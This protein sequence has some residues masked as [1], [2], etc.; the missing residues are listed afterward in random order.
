M[1]KVAADANALAKG[2]KSGAIGPSLQVVEAEMAMD[3]I[4]NG[5][6]TRP[7]RRRFVERSPSKIKKLAVNFTVPARQHERERLD[8]DLSNVVLRR[9]G[10]VG[11]QFARITNGCVVQ[12]TKDTP[13]GVD[14]P[15]MVTETVN[16]LLDRQFRLQS[17]IFPADE[18]VFA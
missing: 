15:A 18:V 11:V 2:V 10:R 14:A 8:R 1:G 4:A 16:V 12:K 6:H 9:V 17:E 3:E 5:L 7:S 13:W